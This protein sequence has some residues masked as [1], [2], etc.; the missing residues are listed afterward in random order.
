VA[1]LTVVAAAV[2]ALRGGQTPCW[3]CV[4]LWRDQRWEVITQ[5]DEDQARRLLREHRDGPPRRRE[6]EAG[7]PE[8]EAALSADARGVQRATLSEQHAEAKPQAS[9]QGVADGGRSQ[10][11]S[12]GRAAGRSYASATQGRPCTHDLRV[13]LWIANKG[14]LRDTRGDALVKQASGL[15]RVTKAVMVWTT[16]S[17]ADAVAQLTREGSPV[18]ESDLAQRWLTRYAPCNV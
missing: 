10:Q 11:S 5:E 15:H 2:H 4:A 9:Q 1:Q 16:V 12:Q 7:T 3:L 13:S 17:L 6:P 18:H 14:H 8:P